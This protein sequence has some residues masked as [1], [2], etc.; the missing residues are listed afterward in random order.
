MHRVL[1]ECWDEVEN[2]AAAEM[3]HHKALNGGTARLLYWPS[4]VK[5]NGA[6]G[7]LTLHLLLLG[8][9]CADVLMFNPDVITGRKPL[10]EV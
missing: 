10:F 2:A 3:T 5:G 7:V 9:C 1:A 4:R 6:I 8:R